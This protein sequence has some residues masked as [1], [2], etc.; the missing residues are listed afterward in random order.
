MFEEQSGIALE[1]TCGYIVVFFQCAVPGGFATAVIGGQEVIIVI[2]GVTAQIKTDLF[3]IVDTGGGFCSLTCFCSAGSRIA[4]KMAMM[5]M[6]TSS[7]MS[8][9]CCKKFLFFIFKILG[10]NVFAANKNIQNRH[11][12]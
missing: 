6:T 11:I 1:V 8:V 3:D 9:K 12:I 5:A 2:V 10:L 4:A 7:S